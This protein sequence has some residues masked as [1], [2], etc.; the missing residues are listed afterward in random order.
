MKEWCNQR[1]HYEAESANHPAV[2]SP[3]A[4]TEVRMRFLSSVLAPW[5]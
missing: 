2:P 5:A 3:V 4:S 1:K